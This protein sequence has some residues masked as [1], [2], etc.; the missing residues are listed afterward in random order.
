MFT[1][2]T[3]YSA[4][5][6]TFR[7]QITSVTKLPLSEKLRKILYQR[8]VFRQLTTR[9]AGATVT[10]FAVTE[11]RYFTANKLN[12]IKNASRFVTNKTFSSHCSSTFASRDFSIHSLDDR[13]FALLYR[14]TR[15]H[16]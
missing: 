10:K 15:P 4:N 12:A 11:R 16:D 8:A 13:A 6:F 9:L 2:E 3:P 5:V 7:E 14:N 1:A